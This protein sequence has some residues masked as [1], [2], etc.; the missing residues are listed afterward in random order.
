MSDLFVM[1]MRAAWVLSAGLSI[2]RPYLIRFSMI[3]VMDSPI[4]G[5]S[6]TAT[7]TQTHRQDELVTCFF[8][9]GGGRT[10][11]LAGADTRLIWPGCDVRSGV[12]VVVI[13]CEEGVFLPVGCV[14]PKLKTKYVV[15][16]VRIMDVP[17][18]HLELWNEH[19]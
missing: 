17:R 14:V 8:F 15:R 11:A 1:W 13:I 5:V 16:A 4:R 9:L 7:F 19:V 12:F 18:F 10:A 2:G 6:V 3:C